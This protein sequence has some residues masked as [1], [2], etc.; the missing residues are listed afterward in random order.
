MLVLPGPGSFVERKDEVQA[1][2]IGC[3]WNVRQQPQL[4]C[5]Y[6]AR[7]YNPG[8]PVAWESR[9]RHPPVPEL[10]AVALLH[11]WHSMELPTA[12]VDSREWELV[13]MW[14]GLHKAL[15]HVAAM[16]LQAVALLHRWHSMRLPLLYSTP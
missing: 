9:G 7:A 11:H 4:G 12:V 13:N 5:C 15:C 3:V 16:Q 6:D 2:Q 14:F 1:E 10:Q 8:A